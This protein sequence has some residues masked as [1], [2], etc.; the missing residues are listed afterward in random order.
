MN[1][2]EMIDAI[3]SGADISKA[4]AGRALDSM[5]DAITSA[6]KN[7]D[8]VNLVGFGSFMVRERAA[9]T[10]RN[11]RTGATIEIAAAKNPSFKAGKALKDAV[12]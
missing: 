7:G 6:L 4:A 3:A 9:R 8:T 1:K 2:S 10:G 11:P 5:V 12:N